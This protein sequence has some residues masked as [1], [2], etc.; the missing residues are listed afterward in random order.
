MANLERTYIIPMR[1]NFIRRAKYK[2]AKRAV[3]IVREFLEKHMK[4]SDVKL[5]QM[6]NRELWKRGIK[7]PPG[8]IKVVAIKDDKGTVKAELFGHKYIEKIKVEKVEKSKLEQ[9]KEKMLGKEEAKKEDASKEHNKEAIEHI[10][11]HEHPHDHSAHQHTEKEQ[12]AQEKKERKVSK[13]E[14]KNKDKR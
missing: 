2:R 8:K 5:G 1:K 7:N 13:N 11:E 14:A 6:I 10:N 3:N 12:H 9:L 4:S